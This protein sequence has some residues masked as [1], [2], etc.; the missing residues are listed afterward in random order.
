MES[1]NTN[2]SEIDTHAIVE[3]MG[4]QTVAGHCKTEPFGSVVMLRVDVPAIPERKRVVQQY[5]YEKGQTVE[6]DEVAP[7][8]DGYTQYIGMQS[9]YRL[10]PCT[11]EMTIAA[12]ER[13]RKHPVKL[14]NIRPAVAGALP[15][16]TDDDADD[17]SADD[18]F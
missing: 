9:I 10:T 18:D 11:P 17:E 4:H 2:N 5:D 1:P 7:A 13:K 6:A 12:T 14:L 16:Q 3:I 8:E 15:D